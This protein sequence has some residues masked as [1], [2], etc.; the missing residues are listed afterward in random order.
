[1]HVPFIS[2]LGAIAAVALSAAGLGGV[3]AVA[4]AGQPPT[5][6]TLYVNGSTLSGYGAPV[7]VSA[8][9]GHAG[10]RHADHRRGL[11][12]CSSAAYATIGAAVAAA[13]TPGTH[14]VVCPGIY[15]EDVTIN[16]PVT[17]EGIQAT[18]DATGKPNG[19]TL[20]A[21]AAGTTVKGF[22]IEN[23]VGEGVIALST[24]NVS[25]VDNTVQ[26]ND[27]GVRHAGYEECEET[28]QN[29]FP[30]CGE[31]V[32]LMGTSSSKIIGNTIRHNSGG[33]LMTDET[34]PTGGNVVAHNWVLDNTE[35]CGIT[36]AG[37]N[38]AAAP[39]G[40]PN[41]KAAGVYGNLIEG[42]VAE[43][44]GVAGQGAGILLAAGIPIGGGAVYNNTVSGNLLKGNGLAGV[45]LHNHFPNQDLNGNRIVHNR[46]GTNNVDGDLDFPVP[47]KE[48]TGVFVG[49]AGSP[50]SITIKHNVIYSNH[51]GIFLTGLM[52]TEQITHNHFFEVT[53]DVVGP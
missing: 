47:D 7:S 35:D 38:P 32:H 3:T 39:G 34:G 12:S 19:F 4:S 10:G 40:T 20:L 31:G 21:L 16:S 25:I 36:L 27:K 17:I 23:A 51:Y 30:D 45:T 15:R 2:R 49:T 52:N 1:M 37:H 5:S 50:L 53:T 41:P 33:V 44:N 29:P 26:N 46:I 6:P 42:N 43:G 18:V 22:T 9:S 13:T 24:N 11:A 48:T 28:P 14:I 8:D